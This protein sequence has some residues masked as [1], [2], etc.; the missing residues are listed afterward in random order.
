[1][2]FR[3]DDVFLGQNMFLTDLSKL[4]PNYFLEYFSSNS[5]QTPEDDLPHS[6]REEVCNRLPQ[7]H[8]RGDRLHHLASGTS[9]V[10]GP[11]PYLQEGHEEHHHVRL[12]RERL[13]RHSR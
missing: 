4:L 11:A 5:L 13:L 10:P 9:G 1:M 3:T 12:H 8:Q 2:R 7:L 6:R